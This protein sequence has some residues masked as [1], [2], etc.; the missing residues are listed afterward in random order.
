MWFSTTEDYTK[1]NNMK[2]LII[3][4]AL[5]AAVASCKKPEPECYACQWV[6]QGKIQPGTEERC[7]PDVQDWALRVRIEQPNFYP[8][9][10][11]KQ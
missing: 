4:V 5:I 9:C 8:I 10:A 2:Q 11:R 7:G 1:T 6:K 3:A